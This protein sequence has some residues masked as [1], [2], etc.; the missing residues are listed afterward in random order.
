M[1]KLIF[2]IQTTLLFP[3]RLFSKIS[4]FALIRNSKVEKTAAVGFGSRVYG[5]SIGRYTYIGRN[6]TVCNTR[7]GNFCSIAD[8]CIISPGKHPMHMVSTSPVFY[9]RSNVLKKC[10]NEVSFEEYDPISIGNDVWIGT[11][12]LIMGGITVGNGAIIGAGAVVTRD[13]PPYSIVGGVP[14]NIIKMRFDENTITDLEKI[15]WW[16]FDDKQL[17]NHAPFMN[18][19]ESLLNVINN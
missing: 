9:N 5:S 17:L 16:E 14:A 12:A 2:L 18:S 19:P 13:V 11:N 15:S 8:K 1:E 3:L 4:P 10:F 7:V 6:S